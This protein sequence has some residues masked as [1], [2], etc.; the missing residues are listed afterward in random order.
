MLPHLSIFVFP[1]PFAFCQDIGLEP[2]P[3]H[4]KHT[5]HH[6]QQHVYMDHMEASTAFFPRWQFIYIFLVSNAGYLCVTFASGIAAMASSSEAATMDYDAL[7]AD[8][9]RALKAQPLEPMIPELLHR[10][11]E[12][13]LDPSAIPGVLLPHMRLP[14]AD[15]TALPTAGPCIYDGP[16]LLC[17]PD[18]LCFLY[19]WMAGQN[20]TA[21]ARVA[22]DQHGFILDPTLE[23][24]WKTRATTLLHRILALMDFEG[25]ET[26]AN[27]LR[28]GGHPGDEE[29]D[30]YTR[31]LGGAV[32]VTPMGESE[33][34]PVIHGSG[35]VQ[36]EVGFVWS[37]DGSGHAS[38]H[39]ILL[40]SWA[41]LDA[42]QRGWEHSAV[43]RRR[44]RGKQ[45]PPPAYDLPAPTLR[46]TPA[47]SRKPVRQRRGLQQ[48]QA[49]LCAGSRLGPCQFNTRQ[50]GMASQGKA[51][52]R[53][54]IFCQKAEMEGALRTP[55]GRGNISRVLKHFAAFEEQD[56]L[57]EALRRIG[58]WAPEWL[59]TFTG[60]SQETKR[61]KRPAAARVRVAADVANVQWKESTNKRKSCW[62]PPSGPE[63]KTFRSAVL[64]DQRFAK[65]RFFGDVPRRSRGKGDDLLGIVP[66]DSDLPAAN[67]SATSIGLQK[68]CEAGSWGM[69][70]KCHVLQPRPMQ[71]SSLDRVDKPY[72]AAS[73]C[74]R[75][76]AL[77]PHRVPVPEDVPSALRNLTPAIIA[78]LRPLDMDVGPES[79]AENGYR[80]KL[81]MIR[82]SWA[83]ESV[84]DKIRALP[85]EERRQAKVAFKYLKKCEVSEYKDYHARHVDFLT[86]HG[87]NPTESQARRPLHFIEEA[88]LETALWPHLY[89][90][91]A[92]CESFERLTDRRLNQLEGRKRARTYGD[93]D[94]TSEDE[95]EEEKAERRHSIK[96]SFQ[97]K[98]LSPLLGYG[99]DFELLQ[100]V[101]DL[102]LWTDLGSKRNQADRLG[103]HKMRLMMR[104]H[105]MS[106]LYWAD[107]KYG[108]FDLVRQLGFPHL[109][110]TLAPYERSYPYHNYLLDEM[111]KLLCARM[112]LPTFEVMH[113]AHT[114]FQICRGLLAGQGQA[115]GVG[116]TRHVLGQ[117]EVAEAKLQPKVHFFTRLEFQD[118]SKKVGTQRYHGSGRPHVHALFW[119]QDIAAVAL[120][121]KASATQDWS[122]EATHM[123]AYVR[124]SQLDQH[125]DSR[126]PLHEEPSA[127]DPVSGKVQLYHT[128]DDAT[129]GV[130]AFFPDVL[131]ALRCHQDLQL[132]QGRGL[133]LQYVTKY[134]AKWSDSSYDE[135]LSDSAS[136]TSLCRKVL[137]EYHP[138]APEMV[139]QLTQATLTVGVWHLHG[140]ASVLPTTPGRPGRC[141]ATGS[142]VI[143]VMHLASGIHVP[144]GISAEV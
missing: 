99:N 144:T 115:K 75:C 15:P 5:L 76:K 61:Y 97:T 89:W 65:K 23:A 40:R 126:W 132:A 108:L 123:Q 9:Q 28:R 53:C 91:T 120:E 87:G 54:C 140:R 110:W 85:S 138:L 109:Y 59:P 36:C 3:K 17:P 38:G 136:V 92:M 19:A 106:P 4:I 121:T 47:I 64:A 114:M 7:S 29:F 55:R 88:G 83:L 13:D 82:F 31:V 10:A 22:K 122:P 143:Y 94:S 8:E 98:L 124:G 70:P 39:Y 44:L 142:G 113:M 134:V 16:P 118:G 50:V 135:W 104:G 20:P 103:G 81:R 27:K 79:R 93:D 111:S 101:Y 48:G 69:C 95:E 67:L 49:Q 107:L 66:N 45:P 46:K 139:L 51:G 41:T 25:Q 131:D 72:I 52:R 58:L 35:P 37:R 12:V 128:Q 127:F 6:K 56:V 112:R 26:M 119:V 34:F 18:G 130:R 30:Y 105:P 80:K 71:P 2:N 102:H 21:W 1:Q 78:A 73:S 42:S 129:D 96:R 77:H 68:W 86:R 74:R 11:A 117:P 24:L 62:A 133:L 141:A 43:L 60:K 90:E 137:F 116:W 100:Y 57:Q 14:P 33:R 63:R 125:G 84:S 32:L